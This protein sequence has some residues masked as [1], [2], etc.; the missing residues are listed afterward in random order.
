MCP[1]WVWATL[2]FSS[3]ILEMLCEECR[4]VALMSPD[5]AGNLGT[6]EPGMALAFWAIEGTKEWAK[7]AIYSEMSPP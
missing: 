3:D 4:Q 2:S 7:G 1:S 6:E 5:T